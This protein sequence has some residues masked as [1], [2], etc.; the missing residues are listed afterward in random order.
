MFKYVLINNVGRKNC[1]VFCF[2]KCFFLVKDLLCNWIWI[3][4]ILIG[5]EDKW[6]YCFEENNNKFE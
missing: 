5:N 2:I 6:I 3:I 1:M 4:I